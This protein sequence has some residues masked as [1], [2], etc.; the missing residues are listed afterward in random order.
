MKKFAS[1]LLTVVM[2]ATML[3][4][5][6]VPASAGNRRTID[7]NAAYIGK[8][9]VFTN[10]ESENLQSNYETFYYIIGVNGWNYYVAS[11]QQ[12]GSGW[13]KSEANRDSGLFLSLVSTES[14]PAEVR[15]MAEKD[16]PNLST[17]STLSEGSLTIIVGIAAAVIFGLGGFFIGKAAGK[18]K[19][20]AL[21]EGENKDEE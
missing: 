1:L 15:A 3:S 7:A 13:K 10:S 12:L 18:K 11:Y 17:G 19:K 2:L 20:T 4:V 21:A 6:A 9:A 14:I 16:Y 8:W 5:F